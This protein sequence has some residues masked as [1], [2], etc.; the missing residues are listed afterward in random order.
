LQIGEQAGFLVSAIGTYEGTLIF[1]IV[2]ATAL[3]EKS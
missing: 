1:G 3:K 2:D